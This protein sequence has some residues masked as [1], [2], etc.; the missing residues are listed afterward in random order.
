MD[1]GKRGVDGSKT[2]NGTDSLP[3]KGGTGT[4]NLIAVPPLHNDQINALRGNNPEQRFG[5]GK[6]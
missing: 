1:I 3:P 4:E 6:A 5:T 2:R